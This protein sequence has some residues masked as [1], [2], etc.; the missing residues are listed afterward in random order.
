MTLNLKPCLGDVYE[1]RRG[2]NLLSFSEYQL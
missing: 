1:R 2:N